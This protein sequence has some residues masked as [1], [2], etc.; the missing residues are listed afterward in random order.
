MT[1]FRAETIAG[2]SLA[3]SQVT[4]ACSALLAAGKVAV[5]EVKEGERG[6]TGV[7]NKKLWAMLRDVSRHVVWHDQKHTEEQ[8]KDIFTA[9]LRGQKSAPGIDGGVVFFGQ[10]TS[11]MSVSLV[12]ELIELIYYFGAEHQIIWSEDHG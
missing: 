4:K 12:S 3:L 6:R 2:L 7:Q 11:K 5:I 8:W 10:S 9:A 1:A